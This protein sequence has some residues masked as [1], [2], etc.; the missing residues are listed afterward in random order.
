MG[1]ELIIN[2]LKSTHDNGQNS[3][4]GMALQLYTANSHHD[5]N[6]AINGR[7]TGCHSNNLPHHQ[8]LDQ[9]TLCL[10]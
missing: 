8:W 10:V 4:G 2:A 6:Y 3:L 5:A 1:Y 9:A 7:T